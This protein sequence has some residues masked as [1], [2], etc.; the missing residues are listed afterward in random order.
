M[1]LCNG[2]YRLEVVCA[3]VINDEYRKH[4][5]DIYTSEVECKKEHP[6]DKIIHGFHVVNLEN[7]EEDTPDWF[8]TIEEAREWC[9]C[10][11]E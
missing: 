11:L 4:Y 1:I 10:F 9:G 8:Y 7:P 5:G 2:K 3:N 6:Y